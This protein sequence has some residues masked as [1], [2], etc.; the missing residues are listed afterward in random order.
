MKKIFFAL[1]FAGALL[2]VNAQNTRQISGAVVDKNGNPLPG[3]K[4]EATGGAESTITDADGS[5]TIEVSR[6]LKS[7]TATYS[8]MKKNK[9]PI[10]GDQDILFE[11]SNIGGN[12]WF[13][14]AVGGYSFA[15][16]FSVEL[17]F[18]QLERW[19]HRW[20]WYFKGGVDVAG[21]EYYDLEDDLECPNL[22]LGASYRFGNKSV[23]PQTPIYLHFGLGIA[24]GY[25][26]DDYDEGWFPNGVAPA[27]D[28]GLLFKIQNHLMLNIGGTLRLGEDPVADIN[29][30][31][32]YAF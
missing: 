13:V 19:N 29:F 31:I 16:A 24:Q 28:L 9:M 21:D 25:Y 20:G 8:G 11:M 30:G 18:G 26:Y 22:I 2:N 27:L 17:M 6:W 7:L 15:N 1:L 3:A 14:N 4:V 10:R 12:G 32:G 5:F 23:S